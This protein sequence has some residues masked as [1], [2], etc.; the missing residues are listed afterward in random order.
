MVAEAESAWRE[1]VAR[2]IQ[3]SVHTLAAM[4]DGR[5]YLTRYLLRSTYS[6]AAMADGR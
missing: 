4:A 5:Y 1:M 6:L 2:G 3:P